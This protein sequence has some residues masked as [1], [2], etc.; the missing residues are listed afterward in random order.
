MKTIHTHFF[1]DGKTVSASSSSNSTHKVNGGRKK[2]YSPTAAQVC[3]CVG[4]K[5]IRREQPTK[6]V[7]KT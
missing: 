2:P 1:A 3:V 6:S 4:Q 7:A 5:R